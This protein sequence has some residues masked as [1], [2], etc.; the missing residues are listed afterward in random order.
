[1]TTLLEQTMPV[2]HFHEVHNRHVNAGPEQVWA[3]LTTLSLDQLA[4]TKPLVA[5]RHL[6][7][8]P[9]PT[10]PLFTDGPVQMLDVDCPRYAIGGTVAQPWRLRSRRQPVGSLAEFAAFDEPG[11]TK[12][13]TDFSLEPCEGGVLLSTETRG[14]S[15]N[16]AARWRFAAYWTLIRVPSGIVRRDL[17]ATVARSSERAVAPVPAH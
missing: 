10:R 11:W 17:L 9:A 14:Y 5:V 4:V 1:M 16:Q 12:Y 3:A 8:A 7:R 2:Y 6:G 15:T 13:L